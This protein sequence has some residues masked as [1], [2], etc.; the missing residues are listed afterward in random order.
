M[1]VLYFLVPFVLLGIAVMAIAFRGG[2]GAV[3]DAA[4]GAARSSRGFKLLVLATYVLF[5]VAVPALV[6]AGRGEAE[7]GVGALQQKPLTATLE[8]GK[9]LFKAQCASCHNLD[10]VNARGNTGPDLDEIGPVTR[11]RVAT[12][13]KNG[14]SGQNRMPANLLRG[15]DANA[16]AAYVAEVAGR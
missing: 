14:G 10:A 9:K 5:G 4:R 12:A 8:E 13:I 1:E 16:V 6:I 11:E 3:R 2:R 7:G 15:Q